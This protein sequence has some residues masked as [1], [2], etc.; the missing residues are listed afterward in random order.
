MTVA[1]DAGAAEG[2][3]QAIRCDARSLEHAC[4]IGAEGIEMAERRPDDADDSG[5]TVRTA[6]GRPAM[7]G[8]V[9]VS[10]RQ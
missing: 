5:G 8:G 6:T 10:A 7:P 4:L 9:E 2:S 1:V 3:Q